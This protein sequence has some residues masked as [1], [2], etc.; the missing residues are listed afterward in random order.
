MYDRSVVMAKRNKLKKFRSFFK[1]LSKKKKIALIVI[2]LLLIIAIVLGIYFGFFYDKDKGIKDIIKKEETVEEEPK[3]TIV[4]P[5]SKTRPY[6]VMINNVSVARPYQSGLQDAYIIYE[7]VVEGGITRYLALFK[8]VNVERIGTIRSSRHYYLDYVLENDAIYVHWGWSEM[9]QSDISTLGIN[10][11]NG[12]TYGGT[13]FWKDKSL[14]VS[15]EHTAYS[16]TEL[17]DK[18]TAKLNY[19]TETNKDL[20]LN[21]SVE[22][23]DLASDTTA[24]DAT[25]IDIVYS[26]NTKNHYDYDEENKVYKRSVNGKAHTDY[27][28][29]EQYTFK[30]IIVYQVENT[31]IAGDYKGRQNLNNIGSGEGY[32]ISEGKAVEITWSKSNREAQTVYKL[33]STGEELKVNDGNTFIQIQPKGQTLTIS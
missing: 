3:I 32:Y 26:S 1:N 14:P 21:Y 11:I 24:K 6:A 22:S 15:T 29:K 30:N 25:S 5:D 31:T 18:A 7:M 4:D 27:V 12:L 16:S 8:D 19:R 9:A 33:K 20:L 23:V 13:Y 10:N 2:G 17:L 28:T